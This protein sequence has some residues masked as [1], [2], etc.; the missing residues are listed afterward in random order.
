MLGFAEVKLLAVLG[1][2]GALDDDVAFGDVI[3]ARE[4]NEFQA[5]SKAESVETG[6]EVRYSG[7]HW[8]LDYRIRE[9]LSNFEF[10]AKGCFDG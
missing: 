9:A 7:R 1:V 10:S 5:N 8:S 4:I 2:A 3:V 6:Y